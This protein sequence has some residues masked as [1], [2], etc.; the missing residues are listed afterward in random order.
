MCPGPTQLSIPNCIL[1]GSAV[2]AQLTA[3]N[4]Y[5]LQCANVIN[6]P[7]KKLIAAINV[8]KEINRLTA[9]IKRYLIF[10]DTGQQEPVSLHTYTHY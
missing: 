4:P 5:T 9:L 3:E 7:L 2:L 6:V 1:N 10:T 8:I